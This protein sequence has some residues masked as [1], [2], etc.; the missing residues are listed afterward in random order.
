MLI[1]LAARNSSSRD[2]HL[3]EEDVAGILGDAAERGV[4]DGARLLVDFLEHE[5]LVA[6]LFRH[7]RVPG[8][9]LDLAF[10]RAC[11]RSR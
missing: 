8:D 5:V 11:R 4:A 3:V 9:V 10:D 1:F 2:L 7:D 6:A